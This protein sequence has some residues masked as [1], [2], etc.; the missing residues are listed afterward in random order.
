[1]EFDFVEHQLR[2]RSSD[3]ERATV[4]LSSRPVADFY[5]ETM[6]ALAELGIEATIDSRP[7]EV[8]PA[9]PFAED[10]QHATYD[11][12]RGAAV[13]AAA[14]AGR[15]GDGRVPVPL[16]RQGQPGALLLGRDGPGLHP[17][18][19][20]RGPAAPR[21]R[22]QLRGLGDGRGVL[23]RAE[24]LP[25]SGPAAARKARSTPTPTPSR[26]ASPTTRSDRRRRTTAWRTGSSCCRTRQW[27][28]PRTPTG[29]C[30]VPAHH[31]SGRR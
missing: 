27:P 5:R 3:G 31:L 8:D 28:R 4:A 11:P 23:P 21:R 14:G 20:P 1:M 17:L 16:R 2:I 9:I 25:G 13:L 12:Q 30:G 22:A 15:P 24:Q 6:A 7:N 18:L 19:R 10:H 26:T 29:T